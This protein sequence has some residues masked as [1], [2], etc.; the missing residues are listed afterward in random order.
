MNPMPFQPAAVW[1]ASSWTRSQRLISPLLFPS[2]H[3]A[4]FFLLLLFS[5]PPLSSIPSALEFCSPWRPALRLLPSLSS[6]SPLYGMYLN[7][8]SAGEEGSGLFAASRST[9]FQNNV[10]LIWDGF[11]R[12]LWSTQRRAQP[13]EKHV[14]NALER[15]AEGVT[16]SRRPPRTGSHTR[17][18]WNVGQVRR[19]VSKERYT[20]R[21]WFFFFLGFF[22]RL[23]D[24]KIVEKSH[25]RPRKSV[26]AF[27]KSL[28]RVSHQIRPYSGCLRG[29][30]KSHRVFRTTGSWKMT[31]IQV[32]T[33]KKPPKNI[34]I[35]CW[36]RYI[37]LSH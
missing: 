34:S 13:R 6:S 29:D 2:P 22:A 30:Y 31:P 17:R 8:R 19:N 11:R 15:P 28:L 3:P 4:L 16:D 18:L 21:V 23:L 5:F 26:N 32:P 36:K 1:A 14:A 37:F 24:W 9:R 10:P 33:G 27:L 25:A 35:Q 12:K 20:G 7:K